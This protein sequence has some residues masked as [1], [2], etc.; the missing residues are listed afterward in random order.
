MNV[1]ISKELHNRLE[2]FS[3]KEYLF[4]SH[5]HGINREDSDRDCIRVISDDF[6]KLFKTEALYLPNIHSFQ[7]DNVQLNEQIIWMTNRQ[8]YGNLFSGD[9]NMI[10]DIVILSGEWENPLE[11]TFTYKV[12]KGYLGVGKR[13]L[14]L[15]GNNSKK[16][17]HAHR[18]I[19]MA[20]KLMSGELPTKSGIIELKKGELP[21]RM[22]LMDK[23]ADL[24]NKLNTMLDS[25]IISTYPKFIED[26][27]LVKVMI[28]CNN[29]REF[30]YV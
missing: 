30:K 13:D 29:I 16:I 22:E 21:S 9:G 18:S 2:G 7:Y 28:D 19:W 10:S 4:G 8:F 15:H 6:Y 23:E 25:G 5:L 3:Y 26:D 24:R 20:E 17:F 1:K 27:P 11:L 14:K 12:I